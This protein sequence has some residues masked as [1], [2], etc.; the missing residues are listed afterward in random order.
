MLAQAL[1][2]HFLKRGISI[3]ISISIPIPIPISIPIPI[4]IPISVFFNDQNG[5]L[6]Q[7]A[8]ALPSIAS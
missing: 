3:P 1:L 6:K 5:G 2:I 8:D 7:I 4:P